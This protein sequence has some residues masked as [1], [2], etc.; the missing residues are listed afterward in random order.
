MRTPLPDTYPVI[1][2][3]GSTAYNVGKLMLKVVLSHLRGLPGAPKTAKKAI[4][5]SGI[6][7]K[8]EDFFPILVTPTKIE[9]HEDSVSTTFF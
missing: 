5:S 4:C 9:N 3:S 1:Q 7:G 6:K 8:A 2:K